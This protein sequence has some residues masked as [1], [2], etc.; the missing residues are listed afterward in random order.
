[1]VSPRRPRSGRLR[2]AIG[3]LCLALLC[4]PTPAEAVSPE[5]DKA[6]V[7]RPTWRFRRYDRPVKV[8]VL[9]GSIGA[10]PGPGY[11]RLIQDQCAAVDVKNLSK[12]GLGAWALKKRFREQVLKNRYLDLRDGEFW[13]LWAGGLNSIASPE[14]TNRYARDTFV[15]ARARGFHTAAFTLTPWGDDRDKKRW[16]GLT[17]LRYRK[18]TQKVVDYL[19]GRLEPRQALGTQAVKRSV[20]P[21]APWL[22][23][24]LPEVAVDLYDSV[25]RDRDAPGRDV[26][27]MR[28]AL[29]ADRGFQKTLDGLEPAAKAERLGSE[30]AL[31]A[32][33]P[34][35]YLRPELR[36]FDHIHLNKA[37]HRT[38]FRAAC[39]GLPASWKCDCAL[40]E[41]ADSADKAQSSD[42]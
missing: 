41:P 25:L 36:S 42:G 33:I 30:S 10:F 32:D 8:V 2:P 13:L 37:G 5:P 16:A 3:A 39:P 4:V 23:E 12:T 29:E 6:E 14:R 40:P 28:A 15:A 1:M 19:M 20:E 22:P 11:P 21:D 9:A 26:Q 31:A 35:W 18:A 17:G 34:H 38:V 24:E 27:A 7:E